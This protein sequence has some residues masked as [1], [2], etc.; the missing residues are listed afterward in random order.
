ME[1]DK[2]IVVTP[3]KTF[4]VYISQHQIAFIINTFLHFTSVRIRLDN[5]FNEFKPTERIT[6]KNLAK[7]YTYF[8]FLVN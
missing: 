1:E 5:F 4:I 7:N 6:N 8:V 2:I 3:R